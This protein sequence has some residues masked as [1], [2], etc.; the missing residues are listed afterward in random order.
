MGLFSKKK[1]VSVGVTAAR[2]I[3][4]VENPYKQVVLTSVFSK[5]SFTQV[6]LNESNKGLFSKAEQFYNFGKNRYIH[7]LPEGFKNYSDINLVNVSNVLSKIFAQNITV[8]FAKVSFADHKYFAYRYL[9][10]Q[11]G[12]NP[13]DNA[14]GM[15]PVVYPPKTKVVCL[16]VVINESNRTAT[17]SAEVQKPTLLPTDPI[18]PKE[19]PVW[20]I[21]Y[22]FDQDK[23]YLQVKYKLNMDTEILEYRYWYYDV[24]SNTYPEINTI[25]DQSLGSPFYPLVPLR[26]N[27]VNVIDGNGQEKK[28]VKTI[29]G[30]LSLDPKVLT[31]ALMSTDEGNDPNLVDEAF[32]GFF[33]YL[34]TEQKASKLYLWEFFNDLYQNRQITKTVFDTWNGNK[35]SKDTPQ[36][37]LIITERDFNIRLL[38]NYIDITESSGV[39]GS[40]DTVNISWDVQTRFTLQDF[41]FETSQLTLVRQVAANT[42]STIT[43]H[44]LEHIVDVYEGQL[45]STTLADI[46]DPDKKYGMYFPINR[47][48]LKQLNPIDRNIVLTDGISV[49]VYAVQITYVKWYQ[50]GFF[51]VLVLIVAI[52]IAYYT[53]DWELVYEAGLTWQTAVTVIT[54]II[55]NFATIKG[56]E[57]V[58]S[59]IGGEIG[60]IIAAVVAIYALSQGKDALFGGSIA[61]PDLLKTSVLALE[62][63]NN[64]VL[65]ELSDITRDLEDLIKSVKEKKEELKEAYDLLGSESIDYFDIRKGGFYFNPNE[66]PDD[67]FNRTV[68]NKN[69]GTSGYDYISYFVDNALKLEPSSKWEI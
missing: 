11:I 23:T 56:L 38:W 31:D 32:V 19:Y 22:T 25:I 51:K 57:F 53:G 40:V 34:N 10:D 24:M 69:P 5:K 60:A 46:N 21:V 1:K 49:I 12:F 16:S 55:I 13:T 15:P 20:E 30:K 65:D 2:L 44:G 4:K 52:I 48:V 63:S 59:A 58:V 47:N 66:M 68:H 17:V 18:P 33:A 3:E 39:I 36:E 8:E 42:I 7:G 37:A 29:L 28:D 50:R 61:A 26:Q 67:F 27:K 43:I 41:D 14:I 64:I 54:N 9:Q 62:A 35:G 45:H 6:L